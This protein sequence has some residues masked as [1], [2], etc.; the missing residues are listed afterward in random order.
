MNQCI[1]QFGGLVWNITRRYVRPDSDAEDV[2]QETFAELWKK[3][4][5]FDPARASASTFI[6]LVARRRSIDWLRRKSRRPA[7]E[8][9]PEDFDQKVAAPTDSLPRIDSESL[10][11]A[12]QELPSEIRELFQLHFAGGLTHPE[13]ADRTGL[14]LGTVKTRLRRGLITLRTLMR[15]AQP[16]PES[17]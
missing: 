12:L 9:L 13:I 10:Q 5:R 1:D 3:A 14:P 2:V 8:A 17:S 15:G 16:T 4:D 6:G 7:L 11:S